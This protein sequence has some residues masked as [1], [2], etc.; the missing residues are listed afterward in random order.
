[1]SLS[2]PTTNVHPKHKTWLCE[3]KPDNTKC[4]THNDVNDLTCMN[5]G[6]VV[7]GWIKVKAE[8]VHEM[9]IGQLYS[10]DEGREPE[11]Q[12]FVHFLNQGLIVEDAPGN[13]APVPRGTIPG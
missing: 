9:E 10:A 4:N 1:M 8:D 13:N 3:K 6:Y 12:Y 5:C 2:A 11:W 7:D